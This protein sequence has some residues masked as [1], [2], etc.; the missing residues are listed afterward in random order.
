MTRNKS[1]RRKIKSIISMVLAVTCVT[2]L[3]ACSSGGGEGKLENA[4][5]QTDDDWI[6]SQYSYNINRKIYTMRMP[7]YNTIAYDY[8]EYNQCNY[9]GDDAN[10]YVFQL[11]H[12]GYTGQ[13]DLSEGV[14]EVDVTECEDALE[15]SEWLI[16]RT[17]VRIYSQN[18][19]AS[20]DEDGNEIP[21]TADITYTGNEQVKDEDI[22]L[23][24]VTATESGTDLVGY[25]IYNSSR[26][27]TL[28]LSDNQEM[29]D[30]IVS[31][32]TVEK[33]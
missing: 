29:I 14:S 11:D 4:I 33:Q 7:Y 17:L 12:Y 32:I 26:Y 1:R 9:L 10:M 16:E 31:T 22:V 23:Y 24:R 2:A 20:F 27:S 19:E 15:R 13:S 25:W 8:C 3:T 5:I 21:F 18:R 6:N 30:R 28:I